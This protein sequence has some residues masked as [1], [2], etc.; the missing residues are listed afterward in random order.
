MTGVPSAEAISAGHNHAA[1]HVKTFLYHLQMFKVV[2]PT[3]VSDLTGLLRSAL[4]DSAPVVVIEGISAYDN[5]IGFMPKDDGFT[6][7]IGTAVVRQ[8][9]GDITILS[10]GAWITWYVV[11]PALEELAKKGISVEWIDARTLVPFGV[12]IS[13]QRAR[14]PAAPRLRYCSR[15][16]TF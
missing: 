9:G 13:P 11:Q 2:E 14:R 7:P 16:I 5:V 3:T 6:I 8:Q 4:R 12:V 1:L 10:W 15:S